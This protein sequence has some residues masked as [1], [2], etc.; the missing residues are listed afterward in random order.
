MRSYWVTVVLTRRTKWSQLER[1]SGCF[2]LASSCRLRLSDPPR[3]NDISSPVS[4]AAV[5][6]HFLTGQ[7]SHCINMYIHGFEDLHLRAEL[8]LNTSLLWK[9]LS[10]A[11]CNLTAALY[12]C[13]MQSCGLDVAFYLHGPDWLVLQEMPENNLSVAWELRSKMVPVLPSGGRDTHA[14]FLPQVCSLYFHLLKVH[15]VVFFLN[16]L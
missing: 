3:P 5:L 8:A 4:S 2:C 1:R 16:V 7:K 15:V 12:A 9:K 6:P 11:V 10:L 13:R 14:R